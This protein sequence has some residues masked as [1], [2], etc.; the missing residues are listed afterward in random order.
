M[1]IS[2]KIS[3]KSTLKTINCYLTDCTHKTNKEA[4]SESDRR[5]RCAGTWTGV[6]SLSLTA[7]LYVNVLFDPVNLL[8]PYCSFILL[9]Y[10]ICKK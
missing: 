2:L 3:L 9:R 6:L 8:S 5:L 7:G 10:F 1:I 4:V